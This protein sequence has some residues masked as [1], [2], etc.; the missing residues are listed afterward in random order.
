LTQKK[1]VQSGL[2]GVFC[3]RLL[4]NRGDIND[5]VYLLEVNNRDPDPS[6]ALDIKDKKLY[7][8]FKAGITD[9]LKY[10]SGF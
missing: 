2:R 9:Y 6:I 10:L 4:Q 8:N 5:N 3:G 7:R 1:P